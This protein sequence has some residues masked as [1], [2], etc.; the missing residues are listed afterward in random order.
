MANEFIPISNSIAN[1]ISDMIFLQKK[2]KP[3]D[4]LPNEHQLAEELGVS[5]TTIREAVKILVANGVL[6]IE[7]GRGTFVT[8]RP[9]SQNDPL[10]IS[11]IEDKMKLIRNWFEL[12]LILEP[13][14]VRLV[15]ERAS[16]EEIKEIVAWERRD[17][18]LMK[19]GDPYEYAEADQRFHAAIAKATHNNVIELMLP[20][21]KLR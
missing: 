21:I 20:S 12:R 14:N 7:R 15:V 16:D 19:T 2:Y 17:A 1:Q 3:K 8:D 13:A 4:K 11:Y 6:A 10:G 9:D 18:E 5:R